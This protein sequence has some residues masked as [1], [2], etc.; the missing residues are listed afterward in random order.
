MF[1]REIKRQQQNLTIQREESGTNHVA[2]QRLSYL[3]LNCFNANIYIIIPPFLKLI[4]DPAINS[5]KEN[6]IES[7][8]KF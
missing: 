4:T 8:H 1:L 3:R 6:L 5:V 2:P 7:N